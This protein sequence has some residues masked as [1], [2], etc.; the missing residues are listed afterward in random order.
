MWTDDDV[1]QVV[2]KVHMAVLVRLFQFTHLIS[3][4]NEIFC[5]HGNFDNIL[6]TFIILSVCGQL[7][8]TYDLCHNN[9]TLYRPTIYYY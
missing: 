4:K 3:E 5:V 8:M 9:K 1:R 2:T 7:N 6:Y